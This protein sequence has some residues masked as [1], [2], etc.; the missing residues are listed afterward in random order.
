M[1]SVVYVCDNEDEPCAVAVSTYT[2]AIYKFYGNEIPEIIDEDEG[3]R[4]RVSN[5]MEYEIYVP[6]DTDL[7]KYLK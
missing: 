4:L 2:G 5:G 3:Y 1:L 7:S 6:A